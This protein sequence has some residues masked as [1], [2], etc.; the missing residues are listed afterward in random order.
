MISRPL[1]TF[2]AVIAAAILLNGAFSA[3]ALSAA[4]PVLR[5]DGYGP[6]QL[7]DTPGEISRE[8]GVSME[9]NYL[10][11]PCV[12]S[13]IGEGR[14]AVVFAYQLDSAPGLDLIFTVARH[15]VAA[16]GLQVGDSLGRMRQ[17][18][19][20]AHEAGRTGYSGNRRLVVGRG[21]LGILAEIHRGHIV[22]LMAGKRRFFDYVEFCS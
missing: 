5:F 13:S 21:R 12:C 9:C 8:F 22:E 19:P 6:A 11:G 18:F 15:V 17:L 3:P 7:G 1:A 16:R 10:G 4:E 14:A 20:H 2:L